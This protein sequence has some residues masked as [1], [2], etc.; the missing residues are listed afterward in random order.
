M[1]ETLRNLLHRQTNG[2]E[3]ISKQQPASFLTKP[4]TTTDE[5]P[6]EQPKPVIA[7]HCVSPGTT[8]TDS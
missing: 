3:V 4:E 1:F 8:R 5:I 2:E 7:G 6:D